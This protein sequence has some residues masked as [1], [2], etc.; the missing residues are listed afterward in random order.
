[1]SAQT[2]ATV[3]S[4]SGRHFVLCAAEGESRIAVTRGRQL[5][6][7]T[8][9]RVVFQA[10]GSDQAIIE[11]V[12]KRRNLLRRSDA[13]RT[14]AIAANIDQVAV[15]LSGEPPYS[16]SL[17]MRVMIAAAI[18]EVKVLLVAT[19]A[20]VPEAMAR[21]EARLELYASLGYPVLRTA[22][23]ADPD[24]A[25]STL[26]TAF[27]DRKTLLLG[28]SGMGKSTL[29]NLLVPDAALL[30]QSIS[31][32]LQTGRHTTTFTRAFD[33]PQGGRLID[34]P[35]FQTFGLAHLSTSEI[36]HALPEVRPLLGQCRFHNCTHRQE[37]GCAIRT[38][39][40]DGRIDAHRYDCYLAL[41]AEYA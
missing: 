10:L 37:P 27:A 35:G 29:V 25:R 34:S 26:L 11:S 31:Q 19:K 24:A 2:L 23:K 39:V 6:V 3:M 28:Q 1:M 4:A 32:A 15:V 9:D 38:A 33:L 5:D 16:E 18:E 17:L 21:I 7:V 13:R 20:D 14:K 41:R 12:Q 36:E 22:A 8:G 40:E 30:T